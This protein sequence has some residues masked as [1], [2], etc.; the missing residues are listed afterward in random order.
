MYVFLKK[1]REVYAHLVQ[2]LMCYKCS[3]CATCVQPVLQG[4]YHSSSVGLPSINTVI[5]MIQLVKHVPPQQLLLC[6][7]LKDAADLCSGFAT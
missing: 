4:R 1:Y 2:V 7:T 6:E 5:I 3:V